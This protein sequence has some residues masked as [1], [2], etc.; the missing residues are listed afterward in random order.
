[1][2]A[3]GHTR[4]LD[5]I[6]GPSHRRRT[7]H[8][9][10]L[11]EP[12]RQGRGDA[13]PGFVLMAST[14]R[15]RSPRWRTR[16]RGFYAVQFHPEVTHTRQGTKILHRFVHEICGCGH[17]WTMP[18]YAGEAIAK[19]RA[20]VGKGGGDPRPVGRRRFV[21]RRG[22]DPQGRSATS[23]PACSSTTACCAST[24]RGKSWDTFAQ[25]MQRQR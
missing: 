8:A 19:I 5:G 24:R 7:R 9:E 13:A 10:G 2:R 23:S 16:T 21:G 4:F 12:R 25:H 3:R 17:D 18:D 14:E 15:A 22:A 20:Q 6:D 1:V 11:D